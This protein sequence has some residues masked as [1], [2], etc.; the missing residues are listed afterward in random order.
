MPRLTELG[1]GNRRFA[2]TVGGRVGSAAT[3]DVIVAW[4]VCG[5]WVDD[6]A[7]PSFALL[8]VALFLPV[9]TMIGVVQR[10]CCA[11]GVVGC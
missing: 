5:N 4:V 10:L 6:A 7:A 11:S 9:V 8:R 1:R 3:A 2:A